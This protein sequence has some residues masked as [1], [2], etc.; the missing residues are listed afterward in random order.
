MSRS[1]RPFLAILLGAAALSGAS[2]FADQRRGIGEAQ[3]GSNGRKARPVEPAP[4][5]G[6]LN[7]AAAVAA[8]QGPLGP[9]VTGR[10]GDPDE[11][12]ALLASDESLWITDE[13]QLMFVDAV[14]HDVDADG[15]PIPAEPGTP[16]GPPPTPISLLASGLPI[17]HSKPGAPW[18]IYLDFDGE[19]VR[20]FSWGIINR[21]TSGLTLDADPTTFNPDEQAVISRMWGRV[22]EDWAPFDVDVTTERPAVIGLTVLWSIIGKRPGDL[23][24]PSNVGGVSQFSF[25]YVPFGLDHPTFTFWQ[26]FGAADHSTLADVITQENGH[27]FGLLHDSVMTEAGFINEYYGGHGTGPT[28]WGPVMG[29][30]IERNVTQWSKVDYPGGLNFLSGVGTLPTQDD[31]AIIAG[32]LGF[33]ADDAADTIAAAQPLAPPR[34]GFITSTADVDVFALPLVNEVHIEITPFRAGEFTDGGNLDVAAE[35]LNAAGAVVASADDLDQTA[36]TLTAE[37]PLTPHF[38]RV[39]PSSNPANYSTYAS[40]GAYTVTGTFVRVVKIVGFQE[41]LPSALV[42]R[43]RTLPVK[44]T[45]TD[46]VAAA[47][48]L[49]LPGEDAAP[50]DALAVTGCQA[51][52]QGRQHCNLRIPSS[53]GPGATGWILAQYQDADGQWATLRSASAPATLNPTPIA[54]E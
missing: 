38:L 40:L 14:H 20:S 41:P 1:I 21:F 18:T 44:F 9:L 46:T 8:V 27:M 30:P 42:T 53:M 43:G 5:P 49:L 33:R 35:I 26:P 7:G 34:S 2:A 22:A 3:P 12:A 23:G 13:G 15:N 19:L 25:G 4:Q 45:L 24:F 16:T 32:K 37:L 50:A 10:G 6:A 51:Q 36:A 29:A 54:V 17:H 39:R 47:R 48:V 11:Y 31:I 52:T 28:S